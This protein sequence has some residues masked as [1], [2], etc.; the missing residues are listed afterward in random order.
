MY[1]LD[2]QIEK[3]TKLTKE[4]LEKTDISLV[5]KLRPYSILYNL[6]TL[7]EKQLK[8]KTNGK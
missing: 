2:E 4:A 6:K 8:N 1:N 5:E 3:Y 7:K